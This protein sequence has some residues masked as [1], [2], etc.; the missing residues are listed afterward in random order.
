MSAYSAEQLS[1]F[2]DLPLWTVA[3]WGIAVWGGVIGAIFLLFR[4]GIAVRVFLASLIC[5]LLTTFQNYVLS[6]GMEVMGDTF[7]LVFTA[8]IFLLALGLFLYSRAML[9]KG[10][11]K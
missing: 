1:F 2:Y 10:V 7:S 9:Q 11:L 5:M 6:N 8:A 3:C 4:K